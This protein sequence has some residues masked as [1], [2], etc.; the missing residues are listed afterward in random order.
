MVIDKELTLDQSFTPQP[1]LGCNINDNAAFIAQTYTARISGILSG[2]KLN[3]LSKASINPQ[4]VFKI[5]PLRVAIRQV[6]QGFPSTTAI[7]ETIVPDGS[8]PPDRLITFPYPILQEA[9]T[10]Y[11]IVVNYVDAP[12][13][14]VG[15]G[16]GTWYGSTGDQY[17]DGEL[18]YGPEGE[19][20]YASSVKNHDV[21]FQTYVVPG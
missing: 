6:E 4:T 16:L 13:A 9:G 8:A 14:G 2:L 21:Q 18:F 20:W 10:Q 3:V 17:P 1:D 19:T 11:A 7:G 5:Y 12:P 15:H